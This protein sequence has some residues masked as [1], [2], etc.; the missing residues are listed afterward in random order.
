MTPS[1]QRKRHAE[2]KAAK[3]AKRRQPSRFSGITFVCPPGWH[4]RAKPNPRAN[5]WAE[6]EQSRAAA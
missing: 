2:A 4:P 5:Y 3:Q 6:Q 1:M